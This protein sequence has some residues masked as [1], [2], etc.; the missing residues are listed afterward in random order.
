MNALVNVHSAEAPPGAKEA[1]LERLMET[2][3]VLVACAQLR[4]PRPNVYYWRARDDAF[5]V[6]WET[7]LEAFN[8]QLS[9]EVVETARA[10]GVG[11]WRPALD[12]GGNPVLDAEFEPVMVLDVSHVDAR[13]LSKL[14]DKRV[15][16]VDAPTQTNV[17]VSNTTTVNALPPAPRIVRT[18]A[19]AEILEAEAV[20]V[21]EAATARTVDRGE[22]P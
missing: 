8:D 11:A 5:R 19:P 15:R 14:I 16:S 20:E 18:A 21:T 9:A 12:E 1:F 10:L 4:L 2:G 22:H 13:I 7:A 17:V 3:N 6:A